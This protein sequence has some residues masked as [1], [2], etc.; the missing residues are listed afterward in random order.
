[1]HRIDLV[2][3]E[4]GE[5]DLQSWVLREQGVVELLEPGDAPRCQAERVAARRE[6]ERQCFSDTGRRTGDHC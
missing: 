1:M 6:L 5:L 3:I 2:D 4:L